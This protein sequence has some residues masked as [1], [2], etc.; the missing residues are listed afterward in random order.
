MT[1]AVPTLQGNHY[2]Q[3]AITR[4]L[5]DHDTDPLS[6]APLKIEDLQPDYTLR[7]LVDDYI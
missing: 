4:W 5:Q 2:Q 6:R 1:H 3:E 7:G